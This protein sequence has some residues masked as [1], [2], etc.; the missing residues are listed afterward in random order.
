MRLSLAEV[1]ETKRGTICDMVAKTA[2]R[3]PLVTLAASNDDLSL[4][5]LVNMLTRLSEATRGNMRLLI[6]RPVTP[7]LTVPANDATRNVLTPQSVAMGWAAANDIDVVACA[8]TVATAAVLT[9]PWAGN[10]GPSICRWHFVAR[11][12]LCAMQEAP[13]ATHV[14]V[15]DRWTASSRGAAYSLD[16][17]T[18]DQI[19]RMTIHMGC[20][21]PVSSSPS[22]GK[23]PF[24]WML[25]TR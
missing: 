25:P 23:A 12:A 14:G 10:V 6:D 16:H 9:D 24:H 18:H 17:V 19:S 20:D 5:A 3:L 13:G 7:Y 11:K 21:V 2:A 8:D 15:F 1:G 22:V 4:A